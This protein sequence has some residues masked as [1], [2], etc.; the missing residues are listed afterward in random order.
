MVGYFVPLGSFFKLSGWAS[1]RPRG[2]YP[3]ASRERRRKGHVSC[4]TLSNTG[5]LRASSLQAFCSVQ[6]GL[7][8]LILWKTA[9]NTLQKPDLDP[10]QAFSAGSAPG[11]RASFMN[12]Y[13]YRYIYMYMVYLHRPIR[14]YT[15]RHVHVHVRKRIRMRIRTHIH[16]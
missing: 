14:M 4:G 13:M 8:R 12:M 5:L 6:C 9:S 2:R 3:T 1:L 15:H 16:V 7:C 10:Y 11:L